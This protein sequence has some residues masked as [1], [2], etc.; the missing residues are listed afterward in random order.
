[1]YQEN[2]F[3]CCRD[4][5]PPVCQTLQKVRAIHGLGKEVHWGPA[6]WLAAIRS[7]RCASIQVSW[8][9]II[10]QLF[11]DSETAS[12]VTSFPASTLQ[13]SP[14]LIVVKFSLPQ[15]KSKPP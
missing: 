2:T 10:N 5:G 8:P 4:A 1:M 13:G 9:D 12:I 15:G 3:H 6:S 14:P 11:D 7:L